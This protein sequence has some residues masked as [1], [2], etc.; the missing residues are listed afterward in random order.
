M[1]EK[2]VEE[3]IEY[4]EIHL[5]MDKADKVYFRNLLLDSLNLT[6]ASQAD[7]DLEKIKK[8][9][10]PDEILNC[11]ADYAREKNLVDEALI[12]NFLAKI[13]GLVTPSPSAV[14]KTF[15]A[16]YEDDKNLAT[17][18]LY[19]LSIK[20]NY[21][22]KTAVDKNLWWQADYDD[23][24]SLEITINL[25]KPEKSN[26]DIAKLLTQVSTNYPK[27]MLC[28]ENVGFAGNYSKPAR[29]NLRTIDLELDGE[30]WFMQ[31]SP[32][33]YYDEHCIVIN[34]KHSQ[35]TISDSTFRKL[36]QFVEKF[37]QYFVGSNACL[38]IVGG[39]ILNHEHF[40]GGLHMMPLHH[41]QSRRK[42]VDK[43][44]LD[45]GIS[46]LEWYNSCIRIESENKDETVEVA[47]KIWSNFEGYSDESVGIYA[48]TD[49]EKHNTITPVARK[50]C[51]KFIIEII[52]RNNITSEEHPDG[53]FHAHKEFHDVKSEGIGLIEAM[54][55]FILPPRVLK[56]MESEP[57]KFTREYVNCACQN[58]LKNTAIFKDDEKGQNA[59]N[60]FLNK[61]G[62]EEVGK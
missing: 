47:K 48:Q 39:S 16:L 5:G 19:D 38:P 54:G 18:Y 8:M 33:V 29:Q 49:G 10:V 50:S 62:F 53:V 46:I 41:A 11:I 32:Y 35:M 6:Q 37:P 9:T 45:V 61:C 24:Q 27:C 42:F 36:T 20:N 51:D 30:K 55:L 2:V 25:S 7:V 31:Y 3:L 21:I 43:N 1:V 4:A 60:K 17:S 52:L 56:S 26:K 57:S 59:F 28:Y 13:M 22:Q 40:Q 34:K 58:I 12:P 44:H 14:E 23:G 15:N